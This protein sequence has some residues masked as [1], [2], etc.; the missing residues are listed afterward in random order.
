MSKTNEYGEKLYAVTL[1]TGTAW[2]KQILVYAYHEEDA[3]Y[4]AANYCEEHELR[5]L[6]STHEEILA[7]CDDG[8]SVDEYAEA[9]GLTCCGN[10]G[11][12]LQVLAVG[13]GY[14]E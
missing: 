7:L 2:T 6:Y 8:Q 5:G 1:G 11:I 3:V 13:G 14:A 9:N 4:N 10:H 12:Y